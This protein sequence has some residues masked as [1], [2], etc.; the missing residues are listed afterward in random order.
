MNKNVFKPCKKFKIIIRYLHLHYLFYLFSIIHRS[1]IYIE[2]SSELVYILAA[3]TVALR[4]FLCLY[5]NFTFVLHK[6]GLL[7][8]TSPKKLVMTNTLAYLPKRQ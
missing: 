5:Y 8:Y 1:L 7:H 6:D 2:C 3:K 4:T